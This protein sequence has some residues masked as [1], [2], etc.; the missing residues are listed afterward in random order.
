MISKH[1]LRLIL[2][3]FNKGNT[4]QPQLFVLD[5]TNTVKCYAFFY[6][7]TTSSAAIFRIK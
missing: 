4:S 6:S 3:L 1:G 7:G 5:I 2:G